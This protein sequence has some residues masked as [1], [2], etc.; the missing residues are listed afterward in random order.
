MRVLRE[1]DVVIAGLDPAIHAA[2]RRVSSSPVL[3]LHVS[4][5]HRVKPGGDE[6][7]E[8]ADLFSPVDPGY[9]SFDNTETPCPA[10]PPISVICSPSVR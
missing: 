4:M 7:G 6:V 3:S 8:T 5:D 9:R 10:L 2:L 1:N